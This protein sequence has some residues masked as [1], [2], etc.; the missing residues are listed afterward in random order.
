MVVGETT[1]VVS[2]RN[3][4]TCIY[5][6]PGLSHALGI[7]TRL[8]SNTWSQMRM[9]PAREVPFVY[10]RYLDDTLHGLDPAPTPTSWP[11]GFRH[12]IL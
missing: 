1:G 12:L 7:C 8:D 10:I 5:R 4:F 3:G 9:P 11:K 6:D 2:A